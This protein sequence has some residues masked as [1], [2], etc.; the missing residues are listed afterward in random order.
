MKVISLGTFDLLH[1][2]HFNLLKKCKEIS[3]ED[4]VVIALNKD[5]FIERYKGKAPILNFKE[6]KQSLLALPW[7]DQVI[8]NRQ[9]TPST[10]AMP[11]IVES[12]ARMVVIGSDW[13]RRD[14]VGQLHTSW[15]EFDK[16]GIGIIYVNYTWGISTTELKERINA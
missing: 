10:S 3:G 13:A 15:D 9:V 14:Y 2:G 12:G 8:P 5:E 7:V 16:Y 1:V 11:T 4:E 6:R